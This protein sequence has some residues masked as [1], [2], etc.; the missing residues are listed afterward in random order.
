MRECIHSKATLSGKC[1]S[2]P[3]FV[4]PIAFRIPVSGNPV[5]KGYIALGPQ[6][7]SLCLDIVTVLANGSVPLHAHLR[8]LK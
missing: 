3:V 8:E 6:T 5:C 7:L 2:C 1:S 4:C